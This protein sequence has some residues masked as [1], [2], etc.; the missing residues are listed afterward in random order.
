M[1]DVYDEQ[2]KPLEEYDLERGYLKEGTRT[3][4]HP[5]VEGV[6]EQGHYETVREYPETGGKDVT[7]IVDVPGVMA[8]DAWDEEI[9]IQVYVLYTEEELAARK[10]PPPTELE[11]L[12]ADVDFLAA[13]GGIEL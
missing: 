11:R 4:H 3:V 5:T 1:M 7:W 8:E 13:M 6:E 2:G 12:R 9:P 10:D